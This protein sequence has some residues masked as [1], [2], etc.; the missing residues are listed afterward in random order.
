MN[1][2]GEKLESPFDLDFNMV[3]EYPQ[4]ADPSLDSIAASLKLIYGHFLD[5]KKEREKQNQQR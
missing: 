5:L 1:S 4:I 3:E 2:A